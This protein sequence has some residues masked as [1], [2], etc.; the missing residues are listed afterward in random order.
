MKAAGIFESDDLDEEEPDSA[1]NMRVVCALAQ[2]Q[3]TLDDLRRVP[4]LA[5]PFS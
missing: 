1:V 3:C 5:G 2:L 4:L